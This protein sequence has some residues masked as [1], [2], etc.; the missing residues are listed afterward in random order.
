[1]AIGIDQKNIDALIKKERL[2][3]RER[4]SALQ[5]Q[6]SL[7]DALDE[8]ENDGLPVVL[9]GSEFSTPDYSFAE[10]VEVIKEDIGDDNEPATRWY[11]RFSLTKETKAAGLQKI[12]CS[13]PQHILD[14]YHLIA[15]EYTVIKDNH[16]NG[17]LTTQHE[18]GKDLDTITAYFARKGVASNLLKD[19]ETK[20]KELRDKL[21]E[22]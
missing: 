10:K 8:L 14:E 6:R 12:Y 9:I 20:V 19:M 11:L 1:M 22:Y 7:Y 2:A 15:A 18:R 4:I 17:Y 5:K 3:H 16:G 21:P 13:A